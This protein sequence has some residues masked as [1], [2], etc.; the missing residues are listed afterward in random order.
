[1]ASPSG[2]WPFRSISF[3]PIFSS[4]NKGSLRLDECLHKLDQH[5]LSVDERILGIDEW[6]LRVDQRYFVS[7][8]ACLVFPNLDQ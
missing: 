7:M 3:A 2:T 6:L 4:G 8:K 5:L 1:L